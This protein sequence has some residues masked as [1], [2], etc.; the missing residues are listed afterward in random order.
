[1]KRSCGAQKT[2]SLDLNAIFFFV[3]LSIF[4]TVCERLKKEFTKN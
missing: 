1:M 3:V 2:V 4:Q